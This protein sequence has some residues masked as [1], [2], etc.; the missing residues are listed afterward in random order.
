M[1]K[2]SLTLTIGFV[3]LVLFVMLL[4][5]FQVRTTQVAAVTTFSK[6]TREITNAGPY[7]KLPWPIEKVY[8]FDKRVQN[9]EADFAEGMTAD[10]NNLITSVYV[11]W[12]IT[13]PKSFMLRFPGG[14]VADARKN[15]K[16]LLG[17][18]QNA[19][20]GKHPLSDFISTSG[21]GAKFTAIENEILT[22]VQSQIRG[23][24]YGLEI[25]FLG[26]KKLGLPEPTTQAI[27]ERMTSERQMLISKL[28]NEGE[29]EA[30]KIR[31]AADRKAAEVL[32]A[33]DGQALE[34]R[35]KGEA[36]AAKSLAVFQQNPQLAS[37]LF[38]LT[39]LEESLKERSTLIFD[40]QT[41]P[42]DLFRGF[43]TNLMAK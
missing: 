5:V 22:A 23:K 29:A 32:A 4:F 11:G 17:S 1:K 15:L 41:P 31:S 30:Q 18:S 38:R 12:R 2:N 10:N 7:F 34:I 13:D 21:E 19:I 14:S 28:Q 26:I 9:F 42:F 6:V 16:G 36:E 25:E 27:F 39:A 43:S 37:F 40:Q 33:A 20:I 8:Y 35:G 3:L 24:N